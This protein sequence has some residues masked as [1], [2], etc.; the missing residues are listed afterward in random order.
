MNG[1][2]PIASLTIWPYALPPIQRFRLDP[3]R[4][5]AAPAQPGFLFRPVLHLE[6]HFRNMM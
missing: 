1:D 5:A 2:T 4:Q 6:G 3:Q